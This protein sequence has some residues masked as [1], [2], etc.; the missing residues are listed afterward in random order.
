MIKIVLVFATFILTTVSFS[1]S[2]APPAGQVGSTAIHKDSVIILSW[3]NNCSVTRGLADITNPSL[4]DASFGVAPNAV[5]IAD[6]SSVISLGDGG[7]AILSFGTLITNGPGPDFVVFENSFSET[8]LELAFVEVSSDGVNFFRFPAI[9]ETQTTTQIGGFGSVDCRYL[10]NLAGKYKAN[11]GTPFDLND[12]AGVFGLNENAITHVKIID[13]VGSIDPL[14]GT[15]DSQGNYVNDPFTTPFAS[16]GF[17]LDAVGVINEGS[18]D[19]NEEIREQFS[20]F[21]NPTSDVVTI[22]VNSPT[23]FSIIDFKGQ[24]IEKGFLEK[25]GV[26]NLT[27]HS[28]GVYIFKLSNSAGVFTSKLVKQ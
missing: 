27:N 10:H 13:A 14:Y 5:G 17:D 6:G 24:L 22:A 26:V 28:A 23:T 9:S 20:I 15:Q 3:A 8:F 25:E 12:V 19:L 7:E 11:Y 1:Q 2:F 16:S 21:P 4:G 18:L